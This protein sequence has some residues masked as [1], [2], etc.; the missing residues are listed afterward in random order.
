MNQK[1]TVQKCWEMWSIYLLS[2]LSNICDKNVIKR[3]KTNK[4]LKILETINVYEGCT[5]LY[6]LLKIWK[7]KNQT[8][9]NVG[10]CKCMFILAKII[11]KEALLMDACLSNCWVDSPC[12]NFTN[13][14]CILLY[15]WNITRDHCRLC[16]LWLTEDC[17]AKRLRHWYTV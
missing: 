11:K 2:Y 17:C 16:R 15:E 10:N 6:E 3:T 14:P 1:L 12:T 13:P 5:V 8:V 9:K 4:C 7:N